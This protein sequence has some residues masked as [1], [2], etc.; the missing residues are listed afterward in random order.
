M[1]SGEI[2]NNRVTIKDI[3]K[4]ANVSTTAVSMALNSRPGV[5]SQTRHKI[6]GIAEQLKYKPN[7]IAKSLVSRRSHTIGFILNSITDPFFSGYF[8]QDDYM[9]IGIREALFEEGLRIPEDIALIGFDDAEFTSLTGVDLTTISQKKYEMG[10]MGAR[11]LIE[12]IENNSTGVVSQL[13]LEARLIIRKSCGHSQHGY[14]RQP[15]NSE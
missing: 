3:A 8:A 5:S 4:A 1:S 15:C 14:V 9:A 6:Q 10:T 2:I 12:M 7:Y 13:I 11:I